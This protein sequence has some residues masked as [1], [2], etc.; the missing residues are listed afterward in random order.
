MQI[1]RVA[2]ELRPNSRAIMKKMVFLS[3]FLFLF[4]LILFA[5]SERS[6]PSSEHEDGSW[7]T[8]E[9]QPYEKDVFPRHFPIYDGKPDYW[10]MAQKH[11]E[12]IRNQKQK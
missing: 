7:P 1:W 3:S 4:S 10:R 6:E 8:Y 9:P 5:S 12:A 2:P 11:N